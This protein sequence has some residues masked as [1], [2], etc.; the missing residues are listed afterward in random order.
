MDPVTFSPDN[1]SRFLVDVTVRT[2]HA[3][4][5]TQAS[6]KPGEAASFGASDKR[7][8]YGE[9]VLAI[10]LETNGRLGE[11]A[12]STLWTLAQAAQRAGG[13]GTASR[14]HRSW[15]TM[16]QRVVLRAVADV[17][18]LAMNGCQPE[19]GAADCG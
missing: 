3:S 1:F 8:R 15:Q 6:V 9:S 7:E 18:L 11:E 13:H 2:S 19:G 17:A 10:P 12:E 14:I 5:C 16:L 4:R